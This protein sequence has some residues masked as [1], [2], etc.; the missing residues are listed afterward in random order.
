[1]LLTDVSVAVPKLDLHVYFLHGRY[2]YTA[3][4]TLAKAYLPK[5][6]APLK[7]F[8]TYA[9][10]AHCPIFEEPE[11]TRMIL[12]KDMLAGATSFRDID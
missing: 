8:Y 11:R 6:D 2:D 5:L 4:H 3:S 9:D 12:T 10:S 1:M 7:G